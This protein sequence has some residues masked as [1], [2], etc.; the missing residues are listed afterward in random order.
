[1]SGDAGKPAPGPLRTVA[2]AIL[3]GALMSLSGNSPKEIAP[4]AEPP[5]P[6]T[7]VEMHNVNYHYDKDLVIHIR[8]LQGKLIPSRKSIPATFDDKL[9]FSISIDSAEISISGAALSTLMNKYVFSY[10]GSPIKNVNIVMRGTELE[11][12]GTAHKGVDVPFH[13]RATVA[14]SEGRIRL[15]P[16]SFKVLHVPVE[17]AMHLLGL[18]IEDII[19]PKRAPGVQLM[20]DDLILDPS[21][22]LPPPKMSGRVSAVRVEGDQLVQV[23]GVPG[24]RETGTKNYMRFLGGVIR[25][26]KLT[27]HDADLSLIDA[28]PNDPFEFSLERYK[29]QLVAGYSKTTPSFGLEVFMPDITKI[30]SARGNKGASPSR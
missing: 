20:K 13:M 5:A 30:G 16:V 22:M 8:Y 12:T 23:F 26:G 7:H 6:G 29:D 18:H 28:E 24:P 25:F 10:P 17:G 14:A 1:M 21:Q 4:I 2:G 9:S 19:D 11:Q 3:I 15:H 27:M